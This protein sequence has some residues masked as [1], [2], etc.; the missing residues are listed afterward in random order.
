MLK[1][2]KNNTLRH[3]D[4]REK[5]RGEN[6]KLAEV[7]YQVQRE[8]ESELYNMK[9]RLTK[10]NVDEVQ[11][12]TGQYESIKS[13]LEEEINQLKDYIQKKEEEYRHQVKEMERITSA[14]EDKVNERDDQIN[15]LI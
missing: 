5:L 8:N 3:E 10:I 11:K 6:Q 15:H 4:E 1:Q 14:L 2:L 9:E 13:T 12:L 7:L